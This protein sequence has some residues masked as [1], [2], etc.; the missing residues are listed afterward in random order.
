MKFGTAKAGAIF[1]L[2]MLLRAVIPIQFSFAPT[3]ALA[4]IGDLAVWRSDVATMDS[5]PPEIRPHL[6]PMEVSHFNGTIRVYVSVTPIGDVSV[7]EFDSETTCQEQRC[8]SAIS[9][10]PNG[11]NPSARIKVIVLRTWKL[12]KSPPIFAHADRLHESAI[13]QFEDGDGIFGI[14]LFY[15]GATAVERV[16]KRH[17]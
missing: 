5:L 9:V 10:A 4:T 16:N 17:L 6:T 11:E 15:D 12:I 14:Q 1:T 13:V 7:Y 2:A 3:Y 8:L